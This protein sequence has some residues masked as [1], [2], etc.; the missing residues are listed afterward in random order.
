MINL[1]ILE[2]LLN[3]NLIEL[4]DDRL[5]KDNLLTLKLFQI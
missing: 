2:S 3:I 4:V 5:L 1:L